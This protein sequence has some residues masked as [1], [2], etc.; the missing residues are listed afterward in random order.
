MWFLICEYYPSG[1]FNGN[2]PYPSGTPCSDCLT[3][4]SDR[5]TCN[6]ITSGLCDDGWTNCGC[7][8]KML[9]PSPTPIIIPTVPTVSTYYDLTCDGYRDCYQWPIECPIDLHCNVYCKNN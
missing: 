6:G 9:S 4:A 8:T 7:P 2:K 1:N 5:D 3:L